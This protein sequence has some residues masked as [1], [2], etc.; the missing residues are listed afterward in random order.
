[1]GP[2]IRLAG[3]RASESPSASLVRR[4][5]V[6]QRSIPEAGDP[7]RRQYLVRP[8]LAMTWRVDQKPAL[9]F[10]LAFL[11]NPILE[12]GAG[13]QIQPD[14]VDAKNAH[15]DRRRSDAAVHEHPRAGYA[16]ARDRDLAPAILLGVPG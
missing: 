3:N 16:D 12:F 2:R 15:E 5:F 4:L 6:S 7:K 11:R 9:A 8:V 10:S 1:M 14:L 13:R